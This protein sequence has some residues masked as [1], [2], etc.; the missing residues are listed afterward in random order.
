M[1]RLAYSVYIW[2]SLVDIGNS[3]SAKI[4]MLNCSECTTVCLSCTVWSCSM[5]KSQSRLSNPDDICICLNHH[6]VIHNMVWCADHACELWQSLFC[7]KRSWWHA[8]AAARPAWNKLMHASA[9]V[10]VCFNAIMY[11]HKAAHQAS[12]SWWKFSLQD[13]QLSQLAE[14]AGNEVCYPSPTWGLVC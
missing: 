11:V 8:H 13:G 5:S 7:R 12:M 3:T 6:G 2:L 4:S 1:Q 9:G 10:T 14:A